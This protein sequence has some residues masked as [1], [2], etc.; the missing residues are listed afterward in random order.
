MKIRLA[1]DSEAQ[2][3]LKLFPNW[4]QMEESDWEKIHPYWA[5]AEVDGKIIAAVQLCPSLPTGRIEHLNIDKSINKITATK[6][7]HS[8]I[9][10]AEVAMMQMGCKLIAGY[11]EFRNKP[12]KR[13]VQRHYNA[14]CIGSGSM[15][16][17]RLK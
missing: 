5:V 4:E 9:K 6:A 15:L 11:V 14:Q 12:I 2:E 7:A 13:I 16:M 10:Y 8:L 3:V 17:W 1:I